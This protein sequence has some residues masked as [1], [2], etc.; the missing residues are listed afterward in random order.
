MWFSCSVNYTI[1]N[2]VDLICLLFLQPNAL[3]LCV[4]FLLDFYWSAPSAVLQPNAV[5]LS[6]LYIILIVFLMW[7]LQS[8]SSCGG[9]HLFLCRVRRGDLHSRNRGQTQWQH[10]D[11]GVGTGTGQCL[12]LHVIYKFCIIGLYIF[13]V[14]GLVVFYYNVQ[15][16]VYR[17]LIY[18]QVRRQVIFYLHNKLYGSLHQNKRQFKF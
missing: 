14:K 3:M 8:V 17:S 12:Y 2:F 16:I 6:I 9:V 18:N 11:E 15:Q 4:L 1:L 13:K 5:V 7:Y 10:H